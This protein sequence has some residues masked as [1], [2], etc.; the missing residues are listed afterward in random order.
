LQVSRNYRVHDPHRPS[1]VGR[2]S[3][4][5]AGMANHVKDPAPDFPASGAD[6][7]HAI[8]AV[9]GS[10]AVL[11]NPLEGAGPSPGCAPWQPPASGLTWQFRL[12]P[13]QERLNQ[14][15]A[16]FRA[17]FQT[18]GL[19][20]GSGDEQQPE[21]VSFSCPTA[22][23]PPLRTASTSLHGELG[24]AVRQPRGAGRRAAG[25]VGLFADH[26]EAE[27][28]AMLPTRC[29]FIDKGQIDARFVA[30]LRPYSVS[31]NR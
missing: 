20:F 31:S 5:R 6:A 11:M 8:G 17:D 13:A 25:P 12:R 19:L 24:R 21:T 7:K 3:R 27:N 14:C 15:A 22:G 18:F 30:S 23:P 26:S 28:S 2:C 9:N 16:L 4:D 1:G 29:H 10:F